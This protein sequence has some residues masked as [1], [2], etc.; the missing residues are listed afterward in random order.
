[1][2]RVQ[3]SGTTEQFKDKLWP[4]SIRNTFWKVKLRRLAFSTSVSASVLSSD[5]RGGIQDVILIYSWQ[6]H[7]IWQSLGFQK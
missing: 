5:F 7:K 3:F 4:S 2:S 6:N 1:M